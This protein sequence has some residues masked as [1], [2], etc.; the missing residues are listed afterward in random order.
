MEGAITCPN[1]LVEA[2]T[3]VMNTVQL[4]GLTYVAVIVGRNHRNRGS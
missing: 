4:L 1:E 2:V 3:V